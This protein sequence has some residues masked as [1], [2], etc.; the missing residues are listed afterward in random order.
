M[1]WKGL[2]RGMEEGI[3]NPVHKKGDSMKVENYRGITLMYTAYKIYAMV[4]E[5]RLRKEIESKELIPE[6]Q[7]EF[8][9]GRSCEDNIYGLKVVAEKEINGKEGKTFRFFVDQK[10]AFDNV[11]REKMR[12]EGIKE[13]L[14]KKHEETK[15][16]ARYGQEVTEEFWT[17]RG[18]RQGCPLSPLL[19]ITFIADRKILQEETERRSFSVKQKNPHPRKRG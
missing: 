13:G 11:D 10:A 4:M 12:E 9:K 18:I 7:A 17:S 1:E 14:I 3:I 19:F 6:T 16:R 8:M 2:A 15:S 5:G